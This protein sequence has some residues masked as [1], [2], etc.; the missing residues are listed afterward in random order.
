MNTNTSLRFQLA[1]I[2]VAVMAVAGSVHAAEGDQLEAMI[3][4]DSSVE[5]GGGYVDSDNGYFG[6]YNGLNEK[7]WYFLLDGDVKTRDDLTGTWMRLRG[8][9]LGLDSRELRWDHN[10]QGN[11]GY[12]LEYNEIPRFEPLD[13]TT[14]VVGIGG[15]NLTLG[16]VTVPVDLET[17]RKRFGVGF[18][19][20]FASKWGFKLDFRN[21]KKDGERLFGAGSF[22]GGGLNFTPEPID[23]TIR[24][25]DAIVRYTDKKFQL[26]GGY[27]GTQ[28]RNDFK[29]LNWT[30]GQSAAFSPLALPPDNQSHQL[31]VTGGYSFNPTTRGTFKVAY[32]KATQ[33]DT[34]INS[35]SG[36]GLSLPGRADLGGEIETTL[37]QAGISA[38]PMPK[39]SITG[40]VRYEDRDDKTPIAQYILPPTTAGNTWYGQNKP[41]SF[42]NTYGK[43]EASYALPKGFR[44]IGALQYDQKNRNTYPYRSVSHRDKTEEISY[45]AAVRRSISETVTGGLSYTYSDRNG[46]DFYQNITLTPNAIGSNLV[47]PLNYAD[48]KRDKVRL[49]LNWMPVEPLSLQFYVDDITD[50]YEGNRDPSVPVPL[51][52]RNGDQRVYAID[53][54]YSFNQKWQAT[55]WYNYNEYKWQN[56]I[57]LAADT[58]KEEGDAFGVGFRGKP[59]SRVEVGADYSY[60]DIQDEWTQ[61]SLTATPITPLP[62]MTTRLTRLNLFG[63]FTLDKHSGLRVDY[64]YDRYSTDDPTWSTWVPGGT[65]SFLEGSVVSIPSPQKVNFVGVRYF[66]NF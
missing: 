56:T 53:A 51:G 28:Y 6:E 10:R 19:K 12:Y 48:R 1:P 55:A 25:L 27:Y 49:S 63:K 62:I 54:A 34:F 64:I 52:P 9:N 44:V 66:Y 36:P 65:G 29:A 26:V 58:S 15:P 11:W 32:T 46:S 24:L 33:D 18:D 16:S 23:S 17:K 20:M 41:L 35:F 45:T 8:R 7:G 5:V 30:W 13:V 60:S 39:L 40:N 22:G 37:L 42:K 50:K 3:T 2:A 4:P 47:A 14:P 31:Y 38:R 61:Q 57:P 59:H 21:E 43:L